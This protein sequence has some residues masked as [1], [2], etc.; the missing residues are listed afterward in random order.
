MASKNLAKYL[1]DEKMVKKNWEIL[2][3]LNFLARKTAL[4]TKVHICQTPC[5]RFLQILDK[6]Y[7]TKHSNIGQ[8]CI[9]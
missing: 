5:S 6:I 1:F 2:A 4:H 7:E 3:V 8:F 9:T